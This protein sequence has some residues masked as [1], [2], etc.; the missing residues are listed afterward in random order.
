MIS[1]VFDRDRWGKKRV[2]KGKGK[3]SNSDD[4]N[5]TDG[6][7]EARGMFSRQFTQNLLQ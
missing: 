3:E 1:W 7:L 6:V 2:G 4:G 5:D